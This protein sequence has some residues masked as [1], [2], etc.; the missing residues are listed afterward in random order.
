MMER[1]GRAGRGMLVIGLL[2][3]MQFANVAFVG[4]LAPVGMVSR[5]FLL[6]VRFVDLGGERGGKSVSVV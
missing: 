2:I 3:L 1:L 6:S 4:R 5:R